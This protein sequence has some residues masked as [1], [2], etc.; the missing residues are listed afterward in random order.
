[1]ATY[2]SASYFR[3][4][5]HYL[6]LGIILII[7]YLSPKWRNAYTSFRHIAP[8]TMFAINIDANSNKH[9]RLKINIFQ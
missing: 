5:L 3:Y 8:N 2:L 1:M 9:K 4:L 6:V 7:F